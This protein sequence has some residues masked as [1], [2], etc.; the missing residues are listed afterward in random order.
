LERG[1]TAI[2]YEERRE[3]FQVLLIASGG[4][5]SAID[6]WSPDAVAPG[7]PTQTLSG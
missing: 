7:R 4:L 1:D 6:A 5:R 3:G 2:N